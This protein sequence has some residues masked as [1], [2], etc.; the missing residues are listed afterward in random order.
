M[1]PFISKK[2]KELL[3]I[4]YGICVY[5]IYGVYYDFVKTYVAYIYFKNNEEL[6]ALTAEKGDEIKSI[7]TS[8]LQQNGYMPGEIEVLHFHFDSDEN[9]QANYGGNYF[10]ATRA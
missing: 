9:V 1:D 5:E 8:Y 2:V 4:E 6:A 3:C 10:H 7:Y